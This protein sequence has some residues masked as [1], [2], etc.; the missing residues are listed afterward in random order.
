MG[1][2]VVLTSVSLD[3]FFAGPQGELDWSSVDEEL[4]RHLNDVLR[5]AGGFLEGR[6]T[7][8][9]MADY[10]PGAAENPEE[11][12]VIQDFGRIWLATPKA[13]WSTTLP[14]DAPWG[15]AVWRTFDPDQVRR[16]AAEASGDVFI[17]GRRPVAGCRQ[18]GLVDEFR[19]YDR[20]LTPI[21]AA[22]V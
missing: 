15:T 22:I 4:H 19:V 16:F 1:R 13:V 21:E 18:H 7:W 9:L 17:G 14:D 6:V 10:W 11:P 2:V 8:Q 3:G 20:A 12:P 5:D